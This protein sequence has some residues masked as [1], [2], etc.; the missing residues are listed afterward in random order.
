[1][2]TKKTIVPNLRFSSY[3]DSWKLCKLID[4][5]KYTKGFAF[6]S[7]DY[8]GRGIRIVRV[9]D[10]NFDKIKHDNEIIYISDNV[11]EKYKDY[12]IRSGN[13]IITTVGSKPDL[14]ESAVGRGIFVRGNNEGF[15]NQN[16]LKFENLEN[17]DNGFIF[18]LL[19]TIKYRAHI[20]KIARGNANQANI[21]VVDLLNFE[22][23]IPSF[24]E[25][26]KIASFLSAI[27]EK[28]QHLTRKKELLEQY[29]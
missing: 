16:L 15:L 20:K 1:M 22:L 27:D 13:I 24:K 17:I 2:K 21:T 18:C 25:Q 19:S 9:S 26:Q 29:K 23:A 6:K 5:S 14:V 3:I 4:V 12:L 11:S 8:C 28:I 7:I 10:L